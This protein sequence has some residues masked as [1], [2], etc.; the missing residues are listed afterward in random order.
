MAICTN[1]KK[2]L[3][4]NES[5]VCKDCNDMFEAEQAEQ[6]AENKAKYEAE[7]AAKADEAY[8]E[9]LAE[10]YHNGEC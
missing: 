6:E 1:C 8:D 3:L 9:I 2:E 5:E 10:K 4:E 7:Q